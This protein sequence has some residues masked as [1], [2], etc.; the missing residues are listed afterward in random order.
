M[1]IEFR[2]SRQDHN[3]VEDFLGTRPANVDAIWVEAGNVTRQATVI[4]QARVT[5]V[6]VLVEPMT[7][8]LA[9]AGF[10]PKELP[11]AEE[12][13]I[14]IARLS[15]SEAQRDRLI[16]GVLDLQSQ[17][18]VLSPPHFYVADDELTRLNVALAGGTIAA[19]GMPVRAILLARREFLARPGVAAEVAR[20][21]ADVGVTDLDLRL[22]PLGSDDEGARKIRSAYDIVHAF[23]HEGIS[24][25]LGGQGLLGQAG[26]ALGIV[27]RFS[28]GIGMR[29]STDH[30]S[31]IS[32]QRKP[33]SA[34]AKFFGVQPGVWLHGAEVAV[35]R[36]VAAVLLSDPDIRSRI[37]CQIGGCAGDIAK[38]LADARTH[39]LHSRVEMVNSLMERP[40]AWR[41]SHEEDRLRRAL[42]MRAV[43]NGRLPPTIKDVKVH[44]IKT[45]TIEGLLTEI[46]AYRQSLSA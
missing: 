18:T 37:A 42:E 9:D 16:D 25:G 28:V 19:T 40:A 32:N 11:Y 10:S 41:G 6:A 4:E 31:A 21:Y 23:K 24:V 43:V 5:G 36:R 17:A 39:Y 27:D 7:E 33:R 14:D 34:D 38:P 8:R 26:L 45:R 2:L 46:V 44:P 15:R 1:G 22:S 12:T 3:K 30:G 35:P 29:E 13:P 20:R